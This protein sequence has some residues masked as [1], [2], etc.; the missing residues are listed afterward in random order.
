[1]NTR[2]GE[3]DRQTLVRFIE[4]AFVCAQEC[5]RCAAA[6]LP[7]IG[8]DEPEQW[9]RVDVRCAEICERTAR[10]LSRHPGHD[11]PELYAQVEL[12]AETCAEQAER[13]APYAGTET[14]ASLQ[15]EAC[16]RCEKSCRE[17]L[18]SLA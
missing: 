6:C 17:L 8:P 11:A 15:A 9:S 5:E 7:A 4:E 3:A 2:T 13:L 14:R 12:C 10:M 16:A 18:G 1:M